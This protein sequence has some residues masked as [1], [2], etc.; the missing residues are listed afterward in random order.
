M[1][2]ARISN[3]NSMP[4]R[5]RFARIVF[6][7]ILCT[8]LITEK[9]NT[10]ADRLKRHMKAVCIINT[11]M[12]VNKTHTHTQQK[13]KKKK[14]S[15]MKTDKQTNMKKSKNN[16]NIPN[17]K[18]HRKSECRERERETAERE[19]QSK[20]NNMLLNSMSFCWSALLEFN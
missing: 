8:L 20:R 14:P 13:K 2:F 12:G 16:N 18:A 11:Q 5:N 10:S 17:K 4:A 1:L 7:M 9:I 19:N 3:G 15:Y 6:L